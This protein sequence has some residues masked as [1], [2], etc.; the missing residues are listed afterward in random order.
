MRNVKR[1]AALLLSAVVLVSALA[2]CRQDAKETTADEK[3]ITATS[4]SYSK[5]G[6]YTTTVSS[7]NVDLSG[8]SIDNVEVRYANPYSGNMTAEELI[9]ELSKN[10]EEGSIEPVVMESEAE[11]KP[12]GQT[13]SEERYPMSA[14]VESVEANG[15]GGFDVS[16]TDEWASELLTG[17]YVVT[18]R[19]VEG[20]AYVN[21]VFGEVT[22]T[23]D[24]DKMFAS[25]TEIQV[26]LTVNGDEFVEGIEKSDLFLGNAFEKMEIEELSNSAKNLTMKLGGELTRNAA[27]AYQWGTVGVK[28][29]G[30]KNG[31]A[32]V[33]AK[34][35]VDLDHV[36]FSASSLTFNDGRIIADLACSDPE[37]DVYR[38]T[39]ENVKIDGVKIE[40]VENAGNGTVRLTMSQDGVKSVNDFVDLVNGRTLTL[41]GHEETV[42]LSQAKFYPVF[43]YVEQDGDALK[44][45]LKLYVYGGTVDESLGAESFGFDEAFADA[46]VEQVSADSDTVATLLISVP[47]GEQTA[48]NFKFRGGITLKAG[49]VTNSWG[50]KTSADC[51]YTREYSGETLGRDV[52][53]N[54]E[55]LLEIQK[56]TSGQ[57]TTFGQICHYGGVIGQVYGIAKSVL[58]VTGVIKSEHTQVMEELKQIESKIDNVQADVSEI[59]RSIKNMLNTMNQI[60]MQNR[61]DDFE[62]ILVDFRSVLNDVK[63][64]QRR[65]ALD[66]ALQKL[67]DEG[68]IDAMPDYGRIDPSKVDAYVDELC[69]KY[70][71]DVS[72]MSDEEAANYNVAVMDYI[73][74]RSEK[75]SDKQYYPYDSKVLKL[76]ESFSRVCGLLGKPVASNPITFYDELCALTYNFDS[77]TYD[78]R[79]ATRVSLGYELTDAI[80]ALAFHYKVTDDPYNTLYR[81]RANEYKKAMDTLQAMTVSGH[82]ASEIKAN[83]RENLVTRDK[84]ETYIND[85][86]VVA[87]SSRAACINYLKDG[88]WTPI[89]RDLNEGSGGKYIYLGYK[90]T[91]NPYDAI[92]DLWLDTDDDENWTGWRRCG[93]T[94]LGF[95][96]DGDLNKG[97]GGKYLYLYYTKDKNRNQRSL[98]NACLSEITIDS[99]KWSTYKSDSRNMKES[100][101]VPYENG[102]NGDL[103]QGA[104]GSNLYM[105]LT[106]RYDSDKKLTEEVSTGRL[107]TDPEYYP[108]CY[109]LGCKVSAYISPAEIDYRNELFGFFKNWTTDEENE[110][111]R[112]MHFS[113]P[114]SELNAAGIR[115]EYTSAGL[116]ARRDS[117]WIVTKAINKGGHYEG[118]QGNCIYYD[119]G[120][121]AARISYDNMFDY[122]YEFEFKQSQGSDVY[123]RRH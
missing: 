65:G 101:S 79:L 85:I 38:L 81:N 106:Y 7:E 122:N 116:P 32:D 36:G 43:D 19:N 22:L 48:E 61:I 97:A 11:E 29:S 118:L 95:N 105:Y 74:Q 9:K 69:A 110:F 63:S 119:S 88:G 15:A 93:K 76:E 123:F 78:F 66:M 73:D 1:I 12:A 89:D 51:T 109:T 102:L 56:Y 90:T 40:K 3:T 107:D 25:E 44:L 94:G 111:L 71:P 30:L 91:T 103:N 120:N 99:N 100:Y 52:T 24:V 17:N 13:P 70:L 58:E 117:H 5:S 10:P 60:D 114:D 14:K 54:T 108:Y 39:E 27:G 64:I 104:P 41:D 50:E 98:N 121:K 34:V 49:A 2:S 8:L 62:T 113:D 82:P 33:S 45:T 83:P 57:N 87:G 16:F 28:P 4:V 46:K 72:S 80:W 42:D 35:N 20:E 75:K 115:V 96:Y 67:Y 26:T 86:F 55:T 68:K 92:C 84:V 23:P 112:R 47:A 31:Y 53:L 59:K 18:F 6:R 77:Q 21:V 37:V